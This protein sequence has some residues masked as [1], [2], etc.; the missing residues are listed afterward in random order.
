MVREWNPQK[1]Q[2]PTNGADFIRF[3][4]KATAKVT[5]IRA[6]CLV[7]PI[8]TSVPPTPEKAAPTSNHS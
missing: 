4:F 6:A 3:G 2:Q 8:S 1:R 5:D 7:A